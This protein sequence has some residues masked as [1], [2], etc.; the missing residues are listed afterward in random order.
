MNQ[1]NRTL[2]I[3]FA[4]NDNYSMPTYV[5]MYSILAH[6]DPACK[7]H[8]HIID[9][10]FRE[11]SKQKII[12]NLSKFKKD[13]EFSFHTP[14]PERFEMLPQVQHFGLDVY[15]RLNLDTLLPKNIERILYLDSDIIVQQD[16]SHL[17]D[18]DMKDNVIGAVRDYCLT[19]IGDGLPIPCEQLG[20]PFDTPYLNAG[21]LLIDVKKWREQNITQKII[22]TLL[23]FRKYIHH[24]D[25][26]GLNLILYKSRCILDSI[27]NVHTY[28]FNINNWRMTDFRKIIISET[29][30]LEKN[31][32][33]SHFI[34]P[35]PWSQKRIDRKDTRLF[36]HYL[37]KS[38]YY[39][40]SEYWSHYF[41]FF[42]L[43][44]EFIFHPK[45][46]T[47]KEV[48]PKQQ[49]DTTP[50]FSIAMT[51]NNDEDYI[52][53]SLRSLQAQSETQWELVILTNGSHDN[54]EMF[55]TEIAKED[56]RIQIMRC[57]KLSPAKAR[58]IAYQNFDQSQFILF[59]QA[60][61]HL[62]PDALKKMKKALEKDINSSAVQ[63]EA[64]FLSLENISKENIVSVFDSRL[65]MH[66][67]S[68]RSRNAMADIGI[69]VPD[70]K[71]IPAMMSW[72]NS[73]F[74]PAQLLIRHDI[75]KQIAFPDGS[76]FDENLPIV[77]DWDFY[78]RLLQKGDFS[79]LSET[80]LGWYR[81][82]KTDIEF[83]KKDKDIE[84]S[85]Y[86]LRKRILENYFQNYDIKTQKEIQISY[87]DYCEY[88]KP[89]YLAKSQYFFKKYHFTRAIRFYI[90]HLKAYMGKPLGGHF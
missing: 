12:C 84:E 48:I 58:N 82:K 41:T 52:T 69:V 68:R 33:L 64:T 83:A 90:C 88:L 87:M 25:Q 21:V 26:D 49:R 59:L 43:R 42:I 16:I 5:T 79:T 19:D 2:H 3:L 36:W 4:A 39:S 70:N 47:F 60:D 54:T 1:M 86:V 75:A 20:I 22:D 13:I 9:I 66:L 56:K 81:Y 65:T 62:M 55:A 28:F 31:A 29:V 45:K 15:F 74:S 32:I 72:Y 67:W 71:I 30:F 63:S 89:Y 17:L 27:Y 85:I 73:L 23:K 7:V 8:F 78:V 24:A 76:L 51:A 61:D 50:L 37:Y 11:E 77:S 57:D 80:V 46:E 6:I 44:K 18:Y 14:E 10:G 38:G 53:E 40:H 35:K 34:G